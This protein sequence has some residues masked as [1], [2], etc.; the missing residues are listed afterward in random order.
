MYSL[1]PRRSLRVSHLKLSSPYTSL[2]LSPTYITVLTLH[3]L[4]SSF[5]RLSRLSSSYAVFV[6]DIV[7]S[8]LPRPFFFHFLWYFLFASQLLLPSTSILLP[9]ITSVFTLQVLSFFSPRGYL[10]LASIYQDSYSSLSKLLSPQFIL[11]SLV[12][13]VFSH[14]SKFSFYYDNLST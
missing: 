13:S 8:K 6:L 1:S 5:L 2:S 9:L 10:H 3:V 4:S 7:S 11:L 14:V 12:I